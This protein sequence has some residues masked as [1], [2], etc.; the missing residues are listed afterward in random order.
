[1]TQIVILDL[2]FS[3]YALGLTITPLAGLTAGI[4]LFGVNVVFSRW[5]LARHPYGPMEWLW[6]SATYWRWQRWR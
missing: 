2:L 3:N 4:A 6:R 1:M 5:W